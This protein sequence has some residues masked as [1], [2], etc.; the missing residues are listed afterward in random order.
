MMFKLL[1]YKQ[2]SACYQLGPAVEMWQKEATF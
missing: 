2:L 1:F